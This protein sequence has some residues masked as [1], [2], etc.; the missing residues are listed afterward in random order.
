MYCQIYVVRMKGPDYQW[1]WRSQNGERE[2]TRSFSL[3]YDCVED[4][5]KHGIEVDLNA[6]HGVEAPQTT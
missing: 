5:R 3:F 2:S 1:K 6:V 4:A